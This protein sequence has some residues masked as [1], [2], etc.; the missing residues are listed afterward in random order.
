MVVMF[1][2]DDVFQMTVSMPSWKIWRLEIHST[3]GFDGG[4]WVG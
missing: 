3:L 2:D 4:G 1:L